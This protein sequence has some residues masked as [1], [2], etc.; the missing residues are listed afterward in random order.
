MEIKKKIRIK[1]NVM[2]SLECDNCKS[3]FDK[4]SF[5]ILEF[6]RIEQFCGYGSIHG[7]Q[8]ILSIDICQK[9]FKEKFDGLYRLREA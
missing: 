4:D 3:V 6:V 5:E 1:K 9:C 7:D 8:K 2:I